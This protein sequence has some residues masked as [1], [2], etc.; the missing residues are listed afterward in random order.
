M[1]NED[2][3]KALDKSFDDLNNTLNALISKL[4]EFVNQF[5]PIEAPAAPADT[6]NHFKQFKARPYKA[7]IPFGHTYEE[8]NKD[9]AM[10]IMQLLD[11]G[12]KV[13]P[14]FAFATDDKQEINDELNRI[15][16]NGMDYFHH[17]NEN[18]L[19]GLVF[20]IKVIWDE[21]HERFVAIDYQGRTLED[22]MLFDPDTF[23]DE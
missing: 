13:I 22:F 5:K 20:I 19:V 9:Q 6:A 7:Y 16:I 2:L 10:Q 15:A 18:D 3:G 8:F 4:D 14:V 12:A 21:Y 17:E 1:K 11:N 23:F